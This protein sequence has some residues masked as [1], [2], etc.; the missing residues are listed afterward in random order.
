ML[1]SP[2]QIQF[3]T[4][5]QFQVSLFF[6]LIRIKCWGW[7]TCG[8]CVETKRSSTRTPHGDYSTSPPP[9]RNRSSESGFAQNILGPGG[10]ALHVSSWLGAASW[11]QETRGQL[12]GTLWSSIAN[13]E[14][15]A[16]TF[17]FASTCSVKFL[18][19]TDSHASGSH[20]GALKTGVHFLLFCCINSLTVWAEGENVQVK[21]AKFCLW[22]PEHHVSRSIWLLP[23]SHRDA[24][25][26]AVG[27]SLAKLLLFD[28]L[29]CTIIFWFN[30]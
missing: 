13:R 24:A 23:A 3:A 18:A 1:E 8:L 28:T 10:N 7:C 6:P 19:M 22:D 16:V 21:A 30:C 12:S 25:V 29:V 9:A 2:C 26:S 5:N 11:E 17:P 15:N 14:A 27:A 20:Q 4:R